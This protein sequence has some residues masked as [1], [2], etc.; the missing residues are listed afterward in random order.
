MKNPFDVRFMMATKI[1]KLE[2]RIADLESQ[3]TICFEIMF[4]SQIAEYQHLFE[5]NIHIV[6][7][8]RNN[9]TEGEN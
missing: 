2:Q 1:A 8:D 9:Q 6:D 4:D 5:N 7:S 3:L